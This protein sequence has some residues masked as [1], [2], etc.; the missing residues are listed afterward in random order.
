MPLKWVAMCGASSD[1]RN[2]PV[3]SLASSVGSARVATPNFSKMKLF[4]QQSLRRRRRDMTIA[5][6]SEDVGRS[7]VW[8]DMDVTR[9]SLLLASLLAVSPSAGWSASDGRLAASANTPQVVVQLATDVPRSGPGPV[10]N[11]AAID[12]LVNKRS[13]GPAQPANPKMS[14]Q[15]SFQDQIKR[16]W[17]PPSALVAIDV[18]IRLNVDGTLSREPLLAHPWDAVDHPEAAASVLATIKACA[19]FRLPP[20][21]YASWRTI[22]T[23]FGP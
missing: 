22:A 17:K 2:H 13:A 21:Q 16:C 7:G 11:P 9:T 8:G 3:E 15:A 6:G 18:D 5:V 19:P 1:F 20:E 23:T 12:A 14:W 10:F 4:K